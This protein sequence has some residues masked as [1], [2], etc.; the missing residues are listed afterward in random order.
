MPVSLLE[1]QVGHHNSLHHVLALFTG[2]VW[3]LSPNEQNLSGPTVQTKIWV[4]ECP[5][6]N[7]KKLLQ[8]RE[9][10]SGKDFF[11]KVLAIFSL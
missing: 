2:L 3:L 6:K 8:V 10:M 7:C 4:L 9:N 11:E 5:N 1:H